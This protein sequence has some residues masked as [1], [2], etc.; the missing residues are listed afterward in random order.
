MKASR[1]DDMSVCLYL[2][3]YLKTIIFV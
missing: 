1:E 3:C 2:F